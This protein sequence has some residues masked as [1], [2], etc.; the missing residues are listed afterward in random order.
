MDHLKEK[1]I[2]ALASDYA[3]KRGISQEVMCDIL[4]D[5]SLSLK[6]NSSVLDL[7]CGSG[8]ILTPMA[9]LYPKTKFLGYDISDLMLK[10]MKERKDKLN[11]V[12][13]EL[14]QGDFNKKGWSND[15]KAKF[16]TIVLFQGIHFVNKL[17]SFLKE[18]TSL[19]CDKGYVVIASTTHNQFYELPYCNAFKSVLKREL[20]RTPDKLKIINKMYN[21]GYEVHNSIDVEIKKKFENDSEMKKWIELKPF[22]VL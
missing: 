18:L 2:D 16:N 13:V 6:D 9:R 5:L 3:N 19:L 20:N 14:M 17:D 8:R 10:N 15:L 1:I 11:L 4:T 12:N 22:S 21:L 7:G